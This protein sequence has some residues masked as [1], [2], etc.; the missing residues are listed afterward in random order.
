MA[1]DSSQDIVQRFQNKP[2]REEKKAAL[3]KVSDERKE[4]F[5]KKRKEDEAQSLLAEK[6]EAEKKKADKEKKKLVD[7]TKKDL[8]KYLDPKKKF[9]ESIP[10]FIEF[11]AKADKETVK[12]YDES[13]KGPILTKLLNNNNLTAD[14]MMELVPSLA[15]AGVSFT[16]KGA[17]APPLVQVAEAWNKSPDNKDAYLKLVKELVVNGA[18]A[19]ATKNGQDIFKIVPEHK[20]ELKAT[21]IEAQEEIG[22]KIRENRMKKIKNTIKSIRN[23]FRGG[24]DQLKMEG[25][26]QRDVLRNQQKAAGR[27]I[28][29]GR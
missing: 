22:K 12:A 16:P 28:R 1:K 15:A 7:D 3:K 11:L 29:G 24:N 18:H 23:A 17:E 25:V 21:L 13:D 20:A 14:K 19:D 9:S 2:T 26:V 6:N 8:D 27:A 10:K 4:E 5:A